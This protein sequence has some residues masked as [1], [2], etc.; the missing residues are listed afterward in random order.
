LTRKKIKAQILRLQFQ[1]MIKKP[2]KIVIADDNKFFCEAL[3][4][5]LNTHKEFEIDNIFTTIKSLID[6]T[7]KNDLDILILDVN[8]NGESSLDYISEIRK[9][10]TDFK[11]ISLTTLNNIAIKNE[12]LQKGI[13]T[14]I[15]KDSDFST[16]KHTI[17]NC[18]QKN[19]SKSAEKTNMEINNQKI[20]KRK[21]QLLQ[22]FYKY[23]H[24][25]EKEL[26]SILNISE[27]TIKTHKRELFEITQ[28]KS[29]QD[30]LKFG[31]KIGIIVP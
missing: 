14:F 5:S 1:K 2:L 27:S 6:F 19:D 21:I 29:I 30:L 3:K 28:T 16:F 23:A 25:T 7:S 26:S 10:P 13:D 18:Y 17:L 4:D 24:K 8:F 31:I 12:A 9:L 22:D 15:G 11:I 20:S